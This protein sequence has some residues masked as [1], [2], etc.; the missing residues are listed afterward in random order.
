MS[1]IEQQSELS[2]LQADSV[3]QKCLLIIHKA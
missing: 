1:K 3:E 2:H